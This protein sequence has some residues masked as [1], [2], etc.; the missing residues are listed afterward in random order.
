VK[1]NGE[2]IFKPDNVYIRK[3]EEANEMRKGP[4]RDTIR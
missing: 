3:E 1:A 4:I 2:Q